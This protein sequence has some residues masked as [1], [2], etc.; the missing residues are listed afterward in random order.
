MNMKPDDTSF[1]PED[2]VYQ[3][4]EE[5]SQEDT[6][7]D[8]S[9]DDSS[10]T[11]EDSFFDG[12]T[13]SNPDLQRRYKEMQGSYTRKTQ[14]LA[15]LRRTLEEDRNTLLQERQQLYELYQGM[16][17]GKSAPQQ[18]PD[19]DSY[20]DNSGAESRRAPRK[21]HPETTQLQQQVAQIQAIQE[22]ADFERRFPDYA[23]HVPAMQAVYKDTVARLGKP[24]PLDV[25]F[26]AAVGKKQYEDS[27]KAP[28]PKPQPKKRPPVTEGPGVRTTTANA[29][30]GVEKKLPP[31]K[32]IAEAVQRAQAA[33][34]AATKE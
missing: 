29:E 28:L 11:G 20:Y 7:E 34:D 9:S 30:R 26:Y 33:R 17:Q 14:E 18:D 1:P 10:D 13:E 3:D 19:D 4:Q 5:T 32:T 25:L 31:P 6:S 15:E 8:S 22:R 2:D 16:Q 24:L 12:D 27:K 21:D 23:P